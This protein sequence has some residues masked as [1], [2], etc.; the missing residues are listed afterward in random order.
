MKN[1][2][3]EIY[4]KTYIYIYIYIY[5]YKEIFYFGFGCA[6]WLLGSYFPD[7]GLNLGPGQWK[8][9]FLTTGLPRN[10]FY[11]LLILGYYRIQ[12]QSALLSSQLN[13]MYRSSPPIR[14]ATKEGL[15]H[16]W[17][18]RNNKDLWIISWGWQCSLSIPH[19]CTLPSQT[20]KRI[21]YAMGH[22]AVSWVWT[23]NKAQ[24]ALEVPSE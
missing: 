15:M 24:I 9:Q 17:L 12:L 3:I 21:N 10:W 2:A 14:W 13:A 11:C 8:Y 5:I 22:L 16:W 6:T 20:W 1:A 18:L 23:R 7:Q 4:W 19:S